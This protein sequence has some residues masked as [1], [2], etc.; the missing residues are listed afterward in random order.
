MK[1]RQLR[2]LAHNVRSLWNVG[3]F[4]RTCDAFAVEHIYLSGYTGTPP[5]KEITKTAIGA[6]EFVTWEKVTDP[7]ALL[8]ELKRDGWTIVG[9]EITT[10][11]VNL[12]AYKPRK[13][14]CLVVGHE[15][16]GVPED[17]LVLC[18]SLIHI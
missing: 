16:T 14:C 3:A 4:F 5:R 2:L 15:L 10:D 7:V 9:L 17:Q 1:P 8:Q 18:L 13:K 11:A 12:D 6:E